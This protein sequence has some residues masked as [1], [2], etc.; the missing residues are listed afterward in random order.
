MLTPAGAARGAG[1][2]LLKM[3]F[4]GAGLTAGTTAL[5]GALGYFGG[6]SLSENIESGLGSEDINSR[7]KTLL[8]VINT[9]PV[10]KN[11]FEKYVQVRR[12]QSSG[13]D[14]SW[15]FDDEVLGMSS[16]YTANSNKEAIDF[17]N[18]KITENSKG[19][20]PKLEDLEKEFGIAF[21]AP[22]TTDES[23]SMMAMKQ[24]R[25]HLQSLFSN[26]LDITSGVSDAFSEAKSQYTS[27]TKVGGNV[28]FRD[29]TKEQQDALLMAQRE[30]EGFKPGTVSYDLNNPGN[31]VYSEQTARFGAKRDLSGR[32]VGDVKGKFAVFPSLEAGMAA[33]KDLWM[34]SGY[35]DKPLDEALKR[36]TGT[37]DKPEASANYRK[38]IF[39]KLS[40]ENNEAINKNTDA[41]IGLK[42]N[43]QEQDKTTTT[44]LLSALLQAM[45]SATTGTNVTNV[46]NTS[47]S[48]GGVASPYNDDLLTLFKS[49]AAQGF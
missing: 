25:K 8:D 14:A 34:S 4:K 6:K 48:S 5:G 27:P 38:N 19:K 32:G 13:V 2:G 21:G 3:A 10:V 26:N 42:E 30:Q 43:M 9:D 20:K 49:R 37:M 36:W 16:K 17:L 28:T 23:F 31:L 46:N 12:A 11:A 15:T 35:A 29:L 41:V 1:A 7:Q 33:Q 47:V 22:I 39:A 40:I 24:K 18:R 44:E 45:A